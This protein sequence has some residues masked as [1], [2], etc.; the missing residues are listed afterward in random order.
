MLFDYQALTQALVEAKH[1]RMNVQECIPLR[2]KINAYDS[3]D[4]YLLITST[5]FPNYALHHFTNFDDLVSLD[6]HY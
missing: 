1:H 6:T 5:E 2:I 3:R 4:Q